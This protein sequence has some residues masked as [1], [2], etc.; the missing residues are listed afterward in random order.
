[1]MVGGSL[2]TVFLTRGAAVFLAVAFVAG[3][4]GV[5]VFIGFFILLLSIGYSV[6]G[7]AKLLPCARNVQ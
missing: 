5:T 7:Q 6:D 4:G 3:A 2:A 1:M